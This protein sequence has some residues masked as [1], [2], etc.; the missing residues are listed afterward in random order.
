MSGRRTVAVSV[1]SLVF[2]IAGTALA[3]PSA[4]P[5]DRSCLLA[6]NAAANHANHLLLLAQRPVS[7][8]RLLPAEVGTDT[9]R[10]GS[11]PTQTSSP[12]CVLTVEKRGTIREVIGIWRAGAV[13]GW[14]FG[15]SIRTTVPFAANV[16]LLTDGRVTKI[17]RRS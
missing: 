15:R 10:K 13:A 1:A 11:T 6:W 9:W 7:G 5:T 8:L 14:T 12:A 17:Y 3:T 4:Q 16:R 2:A